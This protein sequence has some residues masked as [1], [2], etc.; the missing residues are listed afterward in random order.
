[1][2]NSGFDI[3][4]CLQRICSKDGLTFEDAFDELCPI[5]SQYLPELIN[6][7]ACSADPYTRGKIIELLGYTH[8]ESAVPTILGELEHPDQNVR[9]WAYLAL[10]EIN[11]PI[12]CEHAANYKSSHP[13]EFA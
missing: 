4:E 11:T 2:N 8:S 9:Q 13:S 5:A 10:G 1:M 7:L 3:S 12:S 6:T